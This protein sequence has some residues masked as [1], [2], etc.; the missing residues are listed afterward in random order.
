MTSVPN[1]SVWFGNARI[2]ADL[3]I[4]ASNAYVAWVFTRL[5]RRK[6]SQLSD[7]RLVALFAVLIALCGASH[8]VLLFAD[9]PPASL[10]PT[11]LK[12]LAAAFWV[13]TA[14]R[15]PTII[16]C[17]APP[18]SSAAALGHS[19]RCRSFAGVDLERRQLRSKIRGLETMIRNESWV[20]DKADALSELHEI[21]ADLE[22]EPCKI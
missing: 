19:D 11:L 21:L 3:I 8:F 18:S 5:Y 9:R 15:V 17:L 7:A 14:V 4:I 10:L 1:A 12:T 2:I 20:V 22:A 13:V 6:L 16:S